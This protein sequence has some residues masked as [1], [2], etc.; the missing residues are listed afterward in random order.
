MDKRERQVKKGMRDNVREN[1]GK[2]NKREGRKKNGNRK[3]E[4]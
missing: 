4:E 1:E 2:S 3:K